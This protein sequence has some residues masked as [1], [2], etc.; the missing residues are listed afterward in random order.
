M[1]GGAGRVWRG[2]CPGSEDRERCGGG[3]KEAT[4]HLAPERDAAQ[5]RRGLLPCIWGAGCP[6]ERRGSYLFR[7]LNGGLQDLGCLANSRGLGEGEPCVDAGEWHAGC[8]PP[9]GR[10]GVDTQLTA[11]DSPSPA[12]TGGRLLRT[13]WRGWGAAS[14][15]G[16][17]KA[18]P[19]RR[20]GEGGRPRDAGAACLGGSCRPWGRASGAGTCGGCTSGNPWRRVA[21][22]GWSCRAPREGAPCLRAETGWSEVP[23]AAWAG[24]A[25]GS[26]RSPGA[27]A[28]RRA[29]A[30]FPRGPDS[31]S[32]S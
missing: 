21:G 28:G 27:S 19:S 15:M 29:E 6:R 10:R 24:S 7:G 13:P 3:G 31:S 25:A 22:G 20:A 26:A 16:G 8:R 1:T 2:C 9:R 23:R 30:E 18:G 12:G 4:L 14:G 11:G 5:G 32:G 17:W